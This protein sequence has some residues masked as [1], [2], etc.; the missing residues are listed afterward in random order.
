MRSLTT[1]T[2][3]ATGAKATAPLALIRIDWSVPARLSTNGD[4][5]W[6][7]NGYSGTRAVRLDRL[8]ER[9]GRLVI[10]NRDGV[11]GAQCLTDGV[12]AVPV[13]VWLADTSATAAA[14]PVKVFEGLADG[15]E[16][17]ETE[18][19][20]T[21]TATNLDTLTSPRRRIDAAGGFTVVTAG[22]RVTIGGQ[23]VLLEER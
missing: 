21:L 5:V 7:G 3:T 16:I 17:T 13:T 19:S 23:V 14:D 8:T 4:Q 11:Y 22:R 10:D 12:A 18:V 2:A 15:C 6:D 1:A 20:L 9:G